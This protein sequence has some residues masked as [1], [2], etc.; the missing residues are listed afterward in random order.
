MDGYR[1]P[2]VS[3]MMQQNNKQQYMFFLLFMR[4]LKIKFIANFLYFYFYDDVSLL[5]LREPM[6]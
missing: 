1:V 3:L 5:C 2:S 4:D 6:D